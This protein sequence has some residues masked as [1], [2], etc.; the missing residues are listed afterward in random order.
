MGETN[1]RLIV[2][3]TLWCGGTRRTRKL[4]DQYQIPY[5]WIDIDKDREGEAFVISVNHGYRSVP[6]LVF[7]DGSRLTEPSDTQ[8]MNKL[9]L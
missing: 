2:Y 4:L 3:G 8:L 7:P 6:T 1:N 9:G 5:E